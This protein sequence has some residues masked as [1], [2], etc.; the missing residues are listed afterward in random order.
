MKKKKLI[1]YFNEFISE[2]RKKL[3]SKKLS[4]RTKHVTIVL[5]DVYQSRNISACIRS[6]DCFGVQD[7]HV[8]ENRNQYEHDSEV[9]LGSEKWITLNRYNSEKNNTRNTIEILKRKDYQ[10]I[11]TTPHT[12]H[13]IEDIDTNRKIALLFGSENDGLSDE[14]IKLSDMQIKIPTIGFAESL[15]ISVSVA[16]FLHYITSKIKYK[17]IWKMNHEEYE[18]VL[19]QWLRNS[20]KSADKIEELFYKKN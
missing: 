12:E 15:N 9:S 18:E 7:I 4:N 11:A 8:I 2:D 19:L 13:A 3:L 14:A 5:E 10:I 16:I 1:N 17:K 20:I 6:A